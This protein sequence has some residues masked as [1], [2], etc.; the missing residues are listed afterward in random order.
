MQFIIIHKP[1]EVPNT[2]LFK[3]GQKVR[4]SDKIADMLVDRGFATYESGK[5]AN[6]KKAKEAKEKKPKSD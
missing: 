5:P 2:P 3:K 1:V 4:V 6:T